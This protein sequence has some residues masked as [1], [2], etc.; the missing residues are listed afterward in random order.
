MH[1]RHDLNLNDFE[2][3]LSTEKEK[4]SKNIESLKAEVNALGVEDEIDDIEDMAELQIDNGA[5]QT[6]LHSLETE[7]AEVDAALE[8]IKA[9]V[10]GI[11]EKTG[12]KIPVE[13]LLANPSAR[14]VV[15]A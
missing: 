10:Y 15:D 1:T 6:L 11:C 2:K 13:R 4:I 8:R 9:G 7:L 12:H 14:T 3:I 5:D